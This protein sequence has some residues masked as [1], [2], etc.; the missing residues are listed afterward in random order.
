VGTPDKPVDI[1]AGRAATF[2]ISFAATG[3]LAPTDVQFS[4][5]CA[6][7]ASAL[8]IS[9][10]NT[11]LLSISTTS[12]P[13]VIA[14]AVTPTQDGIANI[15]GATG[16]ALFAVATSNVGGSGAI[17]VSGNTGSASVGVLIRVCQTNAA[18]ACI[19][20]PS[21]SVTVQMGAGQTPTFALFVIGTVPVPF[22][23]AANRAVVVFK[24]VNGVT[25]GATSVAIRTQ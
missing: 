6:N 4:F 18:G 24:D 23:P 3:L 5:R 11:L 16:I 9:G 7:T 21:P 14:L 15:P 19:A 13:D 22:A 1:A 2:V 8:P 10:V 20:T 25:R 12:V 17:T